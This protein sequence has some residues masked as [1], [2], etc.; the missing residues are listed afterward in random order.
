MGG[1]VW[2][3]GGA[4]ALDIDCECLELRIMDGFLHYYLTW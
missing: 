4:G 3:V 1:S 2:G